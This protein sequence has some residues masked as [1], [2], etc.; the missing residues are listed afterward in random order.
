[1]AQTVEEL[2]EILDNIKLEADQNAENFEKLL[3]AINNKIE[4]MSNNTEADDLI[5]VYL[6]ELKKILEERH[7]IIVS[8]F[9]KIGN[10]FEALN[11][12]Q[13]YL[14][15][16]AD[17]EEKFE[18]F[19]ANMRSIAQELINQKEILAQYDQRF[20]EFTNDKTDKNAIISAVS[21]IKKDVE[22]INQGFEASI[23]DINSNIQSI[24]K[25]LI[26]MDPT[27]QNDIVKRELENIYLSTNAILSAL[28]NVDQK[29][30]DLIQYLNKFVTKQDYENSQEKLDYII[31]KSELISEKFNN[32]T[33]KTDLDTIIYKSSEI[34]EKINNLPLRE[35]LKYFAEKST[36]IS[37][38]ISLLPQKE[39]IK[40]ITDNTIQSIEYKLDSMSLQPELENISD[41]LETISNKF[42][43]LTEKTDLDKI[44]QSTALIS[45]KMDLLSQKNDVEQIANFNKTLEEQIANLPQQN[46]FADLYSSIHEFSTI[47]DTLRNSLTTTSENSN[48]L[49]REQLDKLNSVLSAVV[50]ENDF[51]GFRQDL[52]DF[53]Q[54]IIDNSVN[55]NENLNL[56]KD[57]LQKLITKIESLDI[58]K[59]I[60]T[61]ADALS[62]LRE[63]SSENINSLTEKIDNVTEKL[64]NFKDETVNTKLDDLNESLINISANIE[65]NQADI[66]EKLSDDNSEKFQSINNNID[67]LRETIVTSQS[68]N[69]VSLTEKLLALRDMITTGI[70]TRDEKFIELQQKLDT[71][72]ENVTKISDNTEL[73]ICNSISEISEIKTELEDISKGLAQWDFAQD[74]RDSK[75][76]NMISSELGDIEVTITTL[77]D[78]IQA[79]VHQ[80]LSKNAENAELQ[81]NNL[82]NLIENFKNELNSEDIT[83]SLQ[84][85]FKEIKDKITTIKQ[86]I[87]LVNTD[88]V[89]E[90]NAKTEAIMLAI[91]PVK[92]TLDIIINFLQEQNLQPSVPQEDNSAILA[93]IS[94]I[95]EFIEQKFDNDNDTNSL[96]EKIGNI[97]EE[98]KESLENKITESHEDLKS[99][100]SVALNNDD[101][102]LAFDELKTNLSDKVNNLLNNNL[103]AYIKKTEEIAEQNHNVTELLDILN[104]KID[105]LA[106]SEESEYQLEELE[107]IKNMISSQ[108]NLFETY[109]SANNTDLIE[110]N[111]KEI[112]QKIDSIDLTELKDMR[113]SIISAILN[114]FEQ[115]SFIE[116]SEDIKDFVEEKTD[117]INQNLNEVK[118]QLKQISNNDDGYSY[119]L[120][121]VESD[122]AKL[123]LVLN[124]LSSSTS[125]DEISEI[126]NNIHRIVSSVE[127]L[128][129]SLTQEQITDLKTDFEKLSEDILSISSRTNKL[130]LTSDESYNALNNGLND[131][132]NL[133][134][135]LEERINYLDNKEI[136]ERTEQKI[137]NIAN[138]VTASANSDKVMRQALIYMG[139]WIDSTSENIQALYEQTNKI[140]NLQNSIDNVQNSIKI[141]QDTSEKQKDMIKILSEKFDEE[142]E[143]MDRIELKL[144][145]I[146][147]AIDDVDNSKSTKKIDK[148]E[149]QI[150]KLSENIEK[151]ASYVDE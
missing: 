75:I 98:L 60:T 51:T 135:K 149:K 69:E 14:A 57:V 76:V 84:E 130:L 8:E 17:M 133:I 12:E 140:D 94:N 91:Q 34:S 77:Q 148:I 66:L 31:E 2:A 15:K 134:Y 21:E 125:N 13:K 123:R 85:H 100:I 136:S 118:E 27:A 95:K 5:K 47:L 23:A 61:I 120:Q 16:N 18:T 19:L 48:L 22:I 150:N 24:F 129:S 40:N 109:Q 128:Q 106:V 11:E 33:E 137:D 96:E 101:V 46:D 36:E 10:S 108:K 86:E 127:D 7:S 113:E 131:F 41:K 132:S 78:S 39:D 121:D 49:I 138:I 9:N 144:E 147:S 63:T 4:I 52:A 20:T 56:N 25:N 55:L 35:D 89:D 6:T 82:I 54:K 62:G 53:I 103:D 117:E 59:D 122:I 107:E 81:L 29:N 45:D 58:H 105:I 74:E 28:H 80:E 115:I 88:I 126:S 151:L 30:E 65:N 71:Y 37:T 143:R 26:V 1:M 50:T 64:N 68:S 142:Q 104:Q 139:E 111:L 99:L 97:T 79:G 116:E 3:T 124:D 42:A 114:V 145:K 92:N 73:K 146:L 38:Q 102:S 32:L 70:S 44:I 67:F 112:I 119:T 93:E 83:S 43:P 72:I 141:L 87:N 90:L 110:D